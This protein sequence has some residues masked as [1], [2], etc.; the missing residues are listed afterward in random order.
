MAV[1]LK[2]EFYKYSSQDAL[3]YPELECCAPA[4]GTYF[5]ITFQTIVCVLYLRSSLE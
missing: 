3:L 5:A 4:G 1:P 2:L